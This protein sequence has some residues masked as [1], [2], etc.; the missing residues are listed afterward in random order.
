MSNLL[1]VFNFLRGDLLVQQVLLFLVS[2]LALE[3]A[4]P[5]KY[6]FRIQ[7]KC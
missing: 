6:G 1:E 5:H 7:I 2:D 3:L 4:L